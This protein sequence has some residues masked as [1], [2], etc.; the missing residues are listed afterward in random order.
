MNP[1]KPEGAKAEAQPQP[2]PANRQLT[3]KQKKQIEKQSKK[4]SQK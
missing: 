2:L 4:I 3:P 1:P